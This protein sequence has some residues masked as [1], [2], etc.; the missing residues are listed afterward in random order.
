VASLTELAKSDDEK[1]VKNEKSNPG[2]NYSI[3][4]APFSD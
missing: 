2:R 3:F 1:L 4:K